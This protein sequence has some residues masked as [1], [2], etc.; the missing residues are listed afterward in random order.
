MQAGVTLSCTV[1]LN[2]EIYCIHD[3]GE[4]IDCPHGSSVND[5]VVAIEKLYH[6]S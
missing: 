2:N 4:W 3:G 1:R 6:S 5:L